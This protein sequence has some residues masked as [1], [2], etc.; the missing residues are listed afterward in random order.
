[1]FPLIIQ[2]S[3]ELVGPRVVRPL[4]HESRDGGFGD[5]TDMQH[6]I[7]VIKQF[8]HIYNTPRFF[9]LYS[10]ARALAHFQRTPCN[11]LGTTL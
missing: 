9:L 4:L 5:S 3:K 1:M 8:S 2:V 7:I 10:D 6:I 11:K